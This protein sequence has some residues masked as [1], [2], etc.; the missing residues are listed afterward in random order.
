VIFSKELVLMVIH[1]SL[2]Y[3]QDQINYYISCVV[4]FTLDMRVDSKSANAST[5]DLLVTI[6]DE[7]GTRDV[8]SLSG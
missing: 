3:I 6:T 1:S 5:V 7:R 2:G 8:K 4:P